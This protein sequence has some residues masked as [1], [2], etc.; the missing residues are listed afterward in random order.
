M[1]CRA[2]I[3]LFVIKGGHLV[4]SRCYPKRKSG[5][6]FMVSAFSRFS[7]DRDGCYPNDYS[8]LD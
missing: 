5:L 7:E 2:G 4:T 3:G 8:S 1:H 6:A